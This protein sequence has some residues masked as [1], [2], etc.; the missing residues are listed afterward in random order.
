MK[1]IN[2]QDLKKLEEDSFDKNI[3]RQLAK[4]MRKRLDVEQIKKEQG[5]TPIDKQVFFQKIDNLQIEGLL[6]MLWLLLILKY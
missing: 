4:P 6:K 2:F 1:N 5:F 3:V